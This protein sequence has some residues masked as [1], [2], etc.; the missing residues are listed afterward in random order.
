M[1]VVQAVEQLLHVLGDGLFDEDRLQAEMIEETST[2]DPAWT[3]EE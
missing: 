2:G 3:S 1:Q